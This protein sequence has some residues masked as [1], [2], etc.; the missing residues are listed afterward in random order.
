MEHCHPPND[1]T[2]ES[3]LEKPIDPEIDRQKRDEAWERQEAE[4][5][6]QDQKRRI[7]QN[8]RNRWL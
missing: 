2:P 8:W 3:P 1:R 6:D 5:R 4:R 7:R